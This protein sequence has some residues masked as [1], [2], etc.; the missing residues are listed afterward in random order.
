MDYFHIHS[1]EVLPW[2]PKSPDLNLI[3]SV[4]SEL[5]S[6][7]KRTYENRQDLEEDIYHSWNSLSIEYIKNLYDSM[8][9]RISAV[10][11]S[12]GEPTRY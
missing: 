9:D 3:E 7:L 6:N 1:I 8:C 10:I 2:P 5:K 11:E 12:E 4:W